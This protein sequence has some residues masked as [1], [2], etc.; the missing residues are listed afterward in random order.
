MPILSFRS[1]WFASRSVV[2]L[3]NAYPRIVRTSRSPEGE[4]HVC[5]PSPEETVSDLEGD[6]NVGFFF[7]NHAFNALFVDSNESLSSSW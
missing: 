4:G 1:G 7:Y 6:I 2:P 3:P 5:M